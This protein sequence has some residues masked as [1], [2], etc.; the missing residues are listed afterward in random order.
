VQWP[1]TTTTTTFPLCAPRR[2]IAPRA[3]PANY[4]GQIPPAGMGRECIVARHEM[5]CDGARLIK[6]LKEAAAGEGVRAA[7]LRAA[8][9]KMA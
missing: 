7:R 1:A 4:A 3:L 9:A 8:S 2:T 6:I 5:G